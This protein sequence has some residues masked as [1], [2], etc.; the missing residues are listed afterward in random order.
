MRT[1]APLAAGDAP[2]RSRELLTAVTGT[3]GDMISTMAHSPALL[4]GYLAFSRAMKRVK[5]PRALSEKI[6]LAVQE[7]IGCAACLAAHTAAARAA[8]VSE[9][10][11]SLAR[12][13][14]SVDAREAVLIGFAV[15]VLAE[16]SGLS[17][18]DV[19]ELRSHGWTDRAIADVVG[20]VN[21]NALT[22]SFN[23]VAGIE[24]D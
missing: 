14:T 19:E 10:D 23:L 2:E 5:L 24:P 7:C 16:P 3:A 17:E 22:G 6:S 11:I 21:L 9:A 20:L 13:G 4:E 1:I 18:V 8:G 12:Q 15:R